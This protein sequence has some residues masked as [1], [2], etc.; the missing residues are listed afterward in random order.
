MRYRGPILKPRHLFPDTAAFLIE[1]KRI[2]LRIKWIFTKDQ[3]WFPAWTVGAACGLAGLML[4]VMLF[5]MGEPTVAATVAEVEIPQIEPISLPTFT[6][7]PTTRFAPTGLRSRVIGEFN[8]TSVFNWDQYT[9]DPPVVSKP[10]IEMPTQQQLFAHADPWRASVD[11][12]NQVTSFTPYAAR[13]MS[14]PVTPTTI[15]SSD[16]VSPYQAQMNQRTLGLFVEKSMVPVIEVDQPVTYQIYVRNNSKEP[17]QDVVVRERISAIQ[18]VSN[19]VPPAAQQG[20]ELVWSLGTLTAGQLKTLSVTIVPSQLETLIQMHTQLST[21]SELSAQA[22]VAPE[23]I[24]QKQPEINPAE[25]P[26][27]PEETEKPAVQLPRPFPE[28]KLAVSPIGVLKKGDTLS[29]IF[30]VSNV[31]TA[32]AEDI[33]LNV[34]LTGEFEHRYGKRIMHHISRLEPGETRRALLQAEAKLDGQAQVEASLT[35]QGDEEE[36]RELTIPIQPLKIE[37]EPNHPISAKEKREHTL[38]DY[39]SRL[40][41]NPS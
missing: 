7:P 32:T 36:A 16:L 17:I 29:L 23:T 18:R 12:R 40:V 1:L 28:L 3:D 9:L 27:L 25:M 33:N 38:L 13:G 6:P 21:A 8:R 20:D 41:V 4:A 5:F 22:N 26:L 11:F 15:T 10:I 2:V 30:T 35:M 34:N 31:G 37:K 14:I 39:A 24:W 19:V